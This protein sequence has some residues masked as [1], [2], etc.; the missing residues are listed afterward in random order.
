MA[1][2]IGTVDGPRRKKGKTDLLEAF[3]D[4]TDSLAEAGIREEVGTKNFGPNFITSPTAFY[5]QKIIISVIVN[6]QKVKRY[7][8]S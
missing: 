6:N 8:S 4:G 5:A 3:S 7:N 1:A 2:L